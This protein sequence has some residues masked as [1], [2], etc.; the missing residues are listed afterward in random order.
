M[1]MKLKEIFNAQRKNITVAA[2]LTGVGSSAFAQIGGL[3]KA[4]S[5]ASA[6]QT[7]IFSLVGVIAIIYLIYL[8]VMAFT[9]KKS[10]SDFGWGV[11]YISVV[12]AAVALATWAWT[13]FQ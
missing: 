7:G 11:V 3:T 13:L 10:W 5:T 12:G 8:G 6:I 9:E 4:Q 1:N 2:V